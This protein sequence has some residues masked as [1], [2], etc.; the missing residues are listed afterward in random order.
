MIHLAELYDWLTRS[1]EHW[2]LAFVAV[3]LAAVC[4][5]VGAGAIAHWVWRFVTAG[6][7]GHRWNRATSTAGAP[8]AAAQ[9]PVA[10]AAG[11]PDARPV[12]Q[13]PR[14]TGRPMP[15]RVPHAP[16]VR[17]HEPDEGALSPAEFDRQI[18]RDVD[19]MFT[20]LIRDCRTAARENGGTS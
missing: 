7:A 3:A 16:A 15:K 19:D 14:P 2:T 4:M 11:E 20:I 10:A 18:A 6:C 5:V 13:S 12:Y 8:F 9:E 17:T 1:A